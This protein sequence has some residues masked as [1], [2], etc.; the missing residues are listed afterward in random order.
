MKVLYVILRFIGGLGVLIG[1]VVGFVGLL[2]HSYAE[3]KLK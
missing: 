2:L 1:L 3:R